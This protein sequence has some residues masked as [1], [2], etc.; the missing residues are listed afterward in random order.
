MVGK[1]LGNRY[2]LLELIGEGGMAQVYKAEDSILCRTVA[3]KI[4]RSQYAGDAEF[5]ERFR[6]EARA[7][8][9]LSHP[10]IVNIYDVGQENGTDYIVMEYLPGCTLKQVIKDEAP[11]PV[12]RA[13]DIT[14]QIA[15]GLNHAHQRNI[16]HRDIKPHNILITPD[17]Q[18]KVTDFGIA[19]AISAG[20]LTQTGEVVGSV[21]Y[22]SPEQA[23]GEAAG[24]QSDLYSLG[25]VLYELL[26]GTVPFKG[27]TLV[28][29]ALQHLQDEVV[30]IRQ[31]RPDL[32]ASVEAIV[33]KA[34]AKDL[35][36]RYPSAMALLKDIYALQQKTGW[37]KKLLEET[38]SPTQVWSA[39][40]LKNTPAPP[41]G[42]RPWLIWLLSGMGMAILTVLLFILYAL[43]IFTPPRPEVTVPNLVGRDLIQARQYLS[44]HQLRLRVVNRLYNSDYPADIIISQKPVA[45]QK[46]RADSEVE[47]V[48]SRGPELVRI[49]DLYGKTQIEAELA[50]EEVGLK[51]GEILT[52]YDQALP[53]S[54]VIK[55]LPEKD[56]QIERGASVSITLN[57]LSG[58]LVQ[59]PNFIGRPLTEVQAEL[60]GYGLVF[61]KAT[62]TPSDIYDVG[63]IVDQDPVPSFRVPEGTAIKFMV[64][65]GPARKQP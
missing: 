24:P 26:T 39:A 58:D 55:Q 44:Q 25:C 35:A 36:K 63:I 48:V 57:V 37:E 45:G 11:L 20:T 52:G 19:R 34:M 7:A 64:S 3:I 27:D 10:N 13:L 21:Q 12:E 31:I 18:I 42:K 56:A 50:L 15:E 41:S 29:I 9:S 59:V 14:R 23:K 47:V 54:T 1:V 46:K 49:P 40:A 38:D 60:P 4:L 22:S 17:G 30:P 6:R 53:E 61:N 16:I 8:A 62:L 43:N 51:L 65:S 2:R 28:S 33:K 5:V 32:P